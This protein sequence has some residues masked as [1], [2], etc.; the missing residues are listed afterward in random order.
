MS[1]AKNQKRTKRRKT[2]GSFAVYIKKVLSPI[3][4]IRISTSALNTMNGLVVLLAEK[5]AFRAHQL[6]SQ[7][8]KSTVSADAVLAA[9]KR[10][11]NSAIKQCSENKKNFLFKKLKIT[12]KT[13][14][15][16]F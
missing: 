15:N 4:G 7:H 14:N 1:E 16:N 10:T 12:F 2:K 8:G 11:I 5:I 6:T 9:L 13:V 3:E